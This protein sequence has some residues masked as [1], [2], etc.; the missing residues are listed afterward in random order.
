MT[1]DQFKKRSFKSNMLY[2]YV[3]KRTGIRRTCL[4]LAVDFDKEVLCL[5]P[6]PGDKWEYNDKA[7][8]WVS[9]E[10]CEL[11]LPKLKAVGL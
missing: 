2:D 9:Y 11:P 3:E 5:W 1:E 10:L 8:F 6:I 4:L 7:E